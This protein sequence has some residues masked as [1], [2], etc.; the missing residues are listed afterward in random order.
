ML[1]LPPGT[2]IVDLLAEGLAQMELAKRL[3]MVSL[4]LLVYDWVII[5]SNIV[6]S[7]PQSIDIITGV[8]VLRCWALYSSRRVLWMLGI[9]LACTATCT[10]AIASQMIR[11]TTF[12]PPLF[13]GILTGCTVIPPTGI[14]LTLIPTTIYESTLFI[15]TLWKLAT[16]KKYFGST[17]LSRRLAEHIKT[18][19]V[20]TNASGVVIAVSSVVCS[21]IIFSLYQL[22]EERRRGP[23]LTNRPVTSLRTDF[24]VPMTSINS[25]LEERF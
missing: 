8:L 9:G 10:I 25:S 15:V 18:I 13:R 24:A 2:N 4:S 23:D 19:Q 14:S 11:G 20:A 21:R 7:L 16:M 3:T 22:D 6:S 1:F 12:L 5:T 17:A